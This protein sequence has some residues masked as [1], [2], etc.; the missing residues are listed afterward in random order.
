MARKRK[1]SS[2]RRRS[3]SIE[4]II[5]TIRHLL[6]ALG[7]GVVLLAV[8]MVRTDPASFGVGA[9]GESW[10]EVLDPRPR[11]PRIGVIAGHWQSDSGAVCPDGLQ[12]VDITLAVAR[13]VVAMLRERG[14]VAEVL[15]EYSRKLDGYRAAA[16]VSLH[17]DSCVDHVSGYKVAAREGRPEAERDRLL[18]EC[19]NREYGRVTGLPRHDLSITEDMTQYHAFRV[20]AT[21]TPAAIIELGFMGGDR[22]LLTT[23]QNLVAQGVVDGVLLFVA[24]CDKEAS[25]TD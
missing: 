7:I 18:V 13:Q 16:M 8:V 21:E 20:I 10:L 25:P 22:E 2:A 1:K 12:E 4:R 17:A 3:A 15:P 5:G 6:T 23:K 19:L 24:A 11:G 14:F 9:E